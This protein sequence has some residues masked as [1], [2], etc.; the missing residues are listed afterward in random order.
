MW[1]VKL[2]RH[3]RQFRVDLPKEAVKR[4][5]FGRVKM[6]KVKENLRGGLLIEG[7]YGNEKGKGEL[8]AG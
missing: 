6:V 4:A 8:Q 2:Q 3:G 1:L 5:A 7:Y